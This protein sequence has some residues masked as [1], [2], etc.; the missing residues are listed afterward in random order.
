MLPKLE[1]YSRVAISSQVR[2][3]LE[4]AYARIRALPKHAVVLAKNGKIV[5]EVV[6][7]FGEKPACQY[8]GERLEFYYR[9]REWI[10]P[11][12]NVVAVVNFPLSWGDVDLMAAGIDAVLALERLPTVRYDAEGR[13][14][15][16]LEQAVIDRWLAPRKDKKGRIR[17][18]DLRAILFLAYDLNEE[19]R[20]HKEK[21]Y[22]PAA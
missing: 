22:T 7:G 13:P 10:R 17:R 14:Q 16:G 6:S 4:L 2:A 11:W 21:K 19:K 9:S 8:A 5:S 20:N 3:D 12:Q 15:P 18:N 1:E